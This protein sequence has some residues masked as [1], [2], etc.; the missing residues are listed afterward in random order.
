[1]ILVT[2]FPEYCLIFA[3]LNAIVALIGIA[4]ERQDTHIR[5]ERRLRTQ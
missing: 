4:F 1:M 5:N 2:A 3:T